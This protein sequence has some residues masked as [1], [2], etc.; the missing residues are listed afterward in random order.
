MKAI[1]TVTLCIL[2]N[3]LLA[4]KSYVY[5]RNLA[6]GD[7]EV[8]ESSGGL[9]TGSAVYKIKKNVYGYLEVESI[10][11]STNPF[12]KRPDYSAYSNFNSYKL[13]AKEIFETLETLNKKNEYD[14][15]ASN[16]TVANNSNASKLIQ[17]AQSFMQNRNKIAS[18]YLSFY[19]SNVD[20]PKKLKDGWYD[21][22]TIKKV[23]LNDVSK[24]AGFNDGYDFSLVICKVESN[25]VTEY[26]ENINVADVKT[27]FVFQK[28]KLDVVSPINNC[29][30][31]FRAFNDNVY[32]SI[33]FLDNI[34]DS[35]KQITNPEFSFYTVYTAANFKSGNLTLN[36]QI[37]RNKNI[38]RDEIV[39]FRGGPY[40]LTVFK[41]NPYTGDCS[42]SVITFAFKKS[43]DKF[44]FGIVRIGDSAIWTIND[45]SF[46]PGTCNSTTLNEK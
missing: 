20:F 34:L 40:I 17:D 5:K 26:Y 19:N 11:A 46:S 15:I 37:A 25:K 44:S 6:T 9:P 29:K 23:E 35:A 8:F 21:A 43:P 33:Y 28:L 3:F 31:T 4:Q 38:T 16:P 27:G 22:I 18:S 45:L 7:L 2:T 10:D 30:S 24:N 39:N 1:I 36:F 41:P 32:S 12:T 42:N 13:P 14:Y